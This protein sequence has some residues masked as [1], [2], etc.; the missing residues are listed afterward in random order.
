MPT[1]QFADDQANTLVR[2]FMA[3]ENADP[4]QTDDQP[5]DPEL[6]SQGQALTARLRCEQCHI[7]SAAGTMSASQLA[8]SFRLSP[9]RLRPEWI[10]RW[11]ADPQAIAPG[12]QM[13]QFWPVDNDGKVITPVPEYLGGD[14]M[15]QM[16]AIAAY[17]VRYGR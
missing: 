11:L 8:P 6:L 2:A 1:F 4:F 16:E 10:A 13:P 17:L 15:R 12:T 7:P 9:D 3:M 14:P 5:V